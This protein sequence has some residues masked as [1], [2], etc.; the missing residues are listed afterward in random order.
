MSDF[1]LSVVAATRN[2]NHGEK[3]QFRM[4]HF[5]DGFVAQCIRH[6]LRAELILVEWNPP[7]DKPPL[8]EALKIP[9]DR[10]PC[11]IRIITVPK[12]VH[13]KLD[14]ADTIPLFQMAAKNVGI[15]R[16]RGKYVLAT[17]IDILFSDELFA[18]F[19]KK[20]KKGV[21]YRVDRLDVPTDIPQTESFE[22]IL[23]FCQKNYFRIHETNRSVVKK[24]DQWK[25]EPSFL[26]RRWNAFRKEFN[27]SLENK[28]KKLKNISFVSKF[29][30]E[31]LTNNA[32]KFQ[33]FL[34]KLTNNAKDFQLFLKKL[35]TKRKSKNIYDIERWNTPL[36]IH[37]IDLGKI[38]FRKV[39]FRKIRFSRL[40]RLPR[41][42]WK[43]KVTRSPRRSIR[44]LIDKR[45]FKITNFYYSRRPHTNACGDFTLLSYEDWKDLKGYPE[46]PI[47]SWHLDSVFLYQA[48][49]SNKHQVNLEAAAP[50]Y[51]I[52]HGKGSGYTPE[53]VDALFERLHKK[54][55]PYLDNAAV[56]DLLK[57]LRRKRK[58]SKLLTYNGE[59]WGFSQYD[60]KEIKF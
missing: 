56:V 22:T 18:F 59:D 4:Q 54:N 50:I 1:H 37:F 29:F 6:N 53:G 21:L 9:E 15:R 60:L 32:K 52:E 14:H 7:E 58:H 24:H 48:I 41:L 43:I 30:K 27:Q 44:T 31:K 23:E 45:F 28:I 33:L 20:L 11:E 39:R 49:I 19:R 42:T 2:D 8:V 35:I 55:I 40:P 36:K 12:Q 16:A 3:L 26:E 25:A 51:H 17:N 5:V 10:G 46:W 13:D 38:R 34:K 47:F 57:E